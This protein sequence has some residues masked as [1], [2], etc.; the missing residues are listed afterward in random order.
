MHPFFVF[1]KTSENLCVNLFTIYP[2][3]R[4]VRELSYLFIYL[5]LLTN[6]KAYNVEQK[7]E[8]TLQVILK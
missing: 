3:I 7:G 1:R 5:F 8:H 2:I 4:L 6:E